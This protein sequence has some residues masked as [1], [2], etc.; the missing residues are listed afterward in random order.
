MIVL[1][2]LIFNDDLCLM[3]V[4]E[5]PVI[6]AFSAKRPVETL[7]RWVLP[8]TAGRDVIQRRPPLAL[9]TSQN[10]QIDIYRHCL[11]VYVAMDQNTSPA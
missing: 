6:E 2:P 9:K 1:L 3:T 11:T 4:G 5:D 8:G 10:L 7:N